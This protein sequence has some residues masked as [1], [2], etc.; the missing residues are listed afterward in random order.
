MILALP[1]KKKKHLSLRNQKVRLSAG[2]KVL[3]TKKT[4]FYIDLCSSF[5][6]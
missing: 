2:S 4:K 1:E 5:V 6:L 3:F